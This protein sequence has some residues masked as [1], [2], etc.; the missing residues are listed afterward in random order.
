[1]GRLL[2]WLR[3]GGVKPML[4]ALILFLLGASNARG[5]VIVNRLSS[6]AA[7]QIGANNSLEVLPGNTSRYQYCVRSTVPLMCWW[8]P[9]ASPGGPDS[10]ATAAPSS[11]IGYP[12]AA[13][14][15]YC[16]DLAHSTSQAIRARMDC[17]NQSPTSSGLVFTR[18]E[19]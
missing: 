12:L 3:T 18:E 7:L 1:M 6:G 5:Q 15:D 11:S 17:Q 13:N 2:N 16:S 8:S 19:Q 4:P 10:V 9:P 14:T